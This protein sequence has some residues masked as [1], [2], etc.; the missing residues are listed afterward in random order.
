MYIISLL[1]LDRKAQ[2]VRL[3]RFGT[4]VCL[5]GLVHTFSIVSIAL[6]TLAAHSYRVGEI[7]SDVVWASWYFY[8]PVHEVSIYTNILGQSIF[9]EKQLAIDILRKKKQKKEHSVIGLEDTSR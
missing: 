6:A 9:G 7:R 3:R 1:K 2:H 8:G 5:D 4:V